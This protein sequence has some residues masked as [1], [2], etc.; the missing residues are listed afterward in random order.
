MNAVT[1]SKNYL[2]EIRRYLDGQGFLEVE[3][4]VYN[5]AGGAARPFITHHNAQSI[6]MV[7]RIATGL[8]ETPYRWW[9]GTRL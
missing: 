1:R 5:E 4:P 9:Y 6:E 3:T 2:R 7:L 8:R